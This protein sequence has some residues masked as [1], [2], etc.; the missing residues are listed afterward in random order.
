MKDGF[1]IATW[2]YNFARTAKVMDYIVYW[3]K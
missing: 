3:K 2:L 1:G